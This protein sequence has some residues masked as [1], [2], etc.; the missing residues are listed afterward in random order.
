MPFAADAT[1]QLYISFQMRAILKT[2]GIYEL[3]IRQIHIHHFINVALWIQ[4]IMQNCNE[5]V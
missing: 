1:R 2:Q 3:L 5:I 4:G